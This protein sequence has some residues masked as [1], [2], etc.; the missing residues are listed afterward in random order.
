MG[1]AGL[2]EV[3]RMERD[4]RVGDVAVMG[5]EERVELEA[6]RVAYRLEPLEDAPR[7]EV[8]RRV[9]ST[10][11]ERLELSGSENR[12]VTLRDA[13]GQTGPAMDGYALSHCA[14]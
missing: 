3:P 14:P 2:P 13:D 8:A 12:E 1:P 4:H 9:V 10:L 7:D 6:L 5:D 11:G